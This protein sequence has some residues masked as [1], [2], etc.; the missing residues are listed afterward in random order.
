[1]QIT[2]EEFAKILLKICKKIIFNKGIEISLPEL[3]SKDLNS[4]YRECQKIVDF[5]K[6]IGYK[7]DINLNNILFP[8]MRDM[9]R[10]FEFALEYATNVDT[11]VM[12]YEQNFSDKN[13]TKLK[14]AKQL[15]AWTKESWVV[16]ELKYSSY[17]NP[18]ERANNSNINSNSQILK[19]EKIKINL[20]K[21]KS[22]G[23]NIPENCII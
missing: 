20:L 3:L 11:G 14:F 12:D 23:T 7:A 8:S 10:I 4:K 22:G 2:N 5:L 16:P 17:F 1:M 21:K 15:T 18:G 6:H 13:F 9:Q 19:L